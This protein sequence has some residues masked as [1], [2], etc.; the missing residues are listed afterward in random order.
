MLVKSERKHSALGSQRKLP[1]S[2]QKKKRN[3]E[4]GKAA[5]KT[6]RRRKRTSTDDFRKREQ[7]VGFLC[8][9]CPNETD[10]AKDEYRI[11]IYASNK[12][13]PSFDI[14]PEG[15][16]NSWSNYHRKLMHI[17]DPAYPG[18]LEYNTRKKNPETGVDEDLEVVVNR[19]NCRT[20]TRPS[21]IQLKNGLA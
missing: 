3:R 14:N 10:P 21:S 1:V 19:G 13:N 8:P 12:S 11:L 20:S 2:I 6:K 16:L 4:E 5:P 9:Q 7:R 17:D 18:G 15:L